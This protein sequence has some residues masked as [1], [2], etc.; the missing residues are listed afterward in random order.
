MKALVAGVLF[1]VLSGSAHA[2]DYS[3]LPDPQQL[4]RSA[5]G[6]LAILK[7][8]AGTGIAQAYNTPK[9]WGRG[10]DGLGK[11]FGA[12]YGKHLVRSGVQQTVAAARREDLTYRRS[13]EKA[14]GARLKHAVFS[15]VIAR[16]SID[17][18]PTV[19]TGRIA[20]A[21][22][23]GYISE[24]WLPD[25]LHTVTNGMASAGVSLGFD[26]LMNIAREFWPKKR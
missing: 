17:G 26:A 23:S 15:T 21:V 18:R 14:V 9:E 19:A 20:G 8:G 25:R 24:L 7:V 13:G 4:A 12:I 16:N 11:R 3:R 10:P 5:F 22:A 6:P 2:V 1:S